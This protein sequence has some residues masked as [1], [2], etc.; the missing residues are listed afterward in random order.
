[1]ALINYSEIRAVDNWQEF[2]VQRFLE[3]KKEKENNNS[4]N[5][6][7]YVFQI[8]YDLKECLGIMKQY[9][10]PKVLRIKLHRGCVEPT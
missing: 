5:R 10:G 4:K 7:P 1:M 3:R 8:L 2:Y 6:G 9:W